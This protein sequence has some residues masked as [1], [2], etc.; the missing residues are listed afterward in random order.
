M[1]I[2]DFFRRQA[3]TPAP[4]MGKRAAAVIGAVR[5]YESALQDRLTAS[6]N[7]GSATPDEEIRGALETTRNRARDLAR[8]NEFARKY[9][10]LVVANVVGHNGFGLQCL[11]EEQGRPD[12]AARDL[13]ERAFARW[14]KRGTCEISGRLSFV[15]VQRAVIE[16]WARDGEALVL[17]LTGKESG[18]AFGYGLRLLEVDR[19]PVQYS[20]DL[21]NGRRAVMGVELDDMNRPVAYWLNLGRLGSAYAQPTRLTR[22][23][24]EQVI[25]VYKP[26][27][28]EQVRG[29]PPMHAV[30]AGLKMLDGY[31]EAAIVAA[32]AGAAKMGFFTNP[33]GDAAALGDDK[34]DEGNFITDADPGSFQVLPKGYDFKTFDPDYPHANYAAFVK[35]RLRGIASGLGIT[36]HGLAND[37]EGVNFSSIR[38][39]TLEERDAWMVLQ[40]WFIEAFMRPVY[41]GWLAEALLAGAI[42][43]PNGSALPASKRD[44]FAAHTWLGRRWGWVDPLKDIEASRLAIKSGIASPQMV[45][46][47]AGVDVE[48][49]L[50]QIADFEQL[51]AKSGVNSVDYGG[52][53]AG[54]IPPE[55]FPSASA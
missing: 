15:D 14:A 7:A 51:V 9:I 18:N 26:A 16:T 27:R 45:A 4:A 42:T 34:D 8:N 49:V 52:T 30:I 46:A 44:K 43:Y 41:H 35:A 25:H 54:N 1:G 3:P 5:S 17:Q 48:D 32:R 6:W 50:Q 55:N 38:S 19:L 53:G 33:D 31:E 29:M 11:A 10:S 37:L 12:T 13:I 28:P 36:Y 40:T 20:Q 21:K 2:L 47:Q 39:G 22:L 24:A 23:P